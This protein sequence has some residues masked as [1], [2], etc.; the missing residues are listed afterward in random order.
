MR[1]DI[2]LIN[3]V[4]VDYNHTEVMNSQT[5][6]SI[7]SLPSAHSSLAS[8]VSSSSS[9]SLP[10]T[11]TIVTMKVDIHSLKK[12]LKRISNQRALLIASRLAGANQDVDL[13]LSELRLVKVDHEL[14]TWRNYAAATKTQRGDKK[15][16]D[17][18]KFKSD[19]VKL[20]HDKNEYHG[21]RGDNYDN[22]HDNKHGHDV[23]QVLLVEDL[24]LELEEHKKGVKEEVR[25]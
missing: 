17:L 21:D 24:I 16:V 18:K 20:S 19:F 10:T 22:D 11:T 12:E 13:K 23:A 7:S 2:S 1:D 3:N 25:L 8:V 15:I 4:L 14:N 6:S 9:S 5:S